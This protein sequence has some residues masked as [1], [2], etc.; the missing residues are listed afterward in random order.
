MVYALVQFIFEER[1]STWN[2]DLLVYCLIVFVINN[3][4]VPRGTLILLIK[5]ILF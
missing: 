5:N 3:I 1:C 4:N 2:I